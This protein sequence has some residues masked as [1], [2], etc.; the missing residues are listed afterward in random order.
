MNNEIQSEE[1]KSLSQREHNIPGHS[2]YVTIRQ[3]DPDSGDW[4]TVSAVDNGDGSYALSS[5]EGV[6]TERYDI[7]GTTIYVGSAAIGTADST[8][9]WVI[10]K[11]DLSDL[12]DASGKVANDVSWDDRTTGTYA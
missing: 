3:F 2:K 6:K 1:V 10:Y 5:G 11:F 4:V 12:T 7:Q 8:A 9:S